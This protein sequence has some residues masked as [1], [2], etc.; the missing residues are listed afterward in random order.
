[1]IKSQRPQSS[2][3]ARRFV[4][5]DFIDASVRKEWTD[6]DIAKYV[7]TY[8]YALLTH[9]VDPD[10]RRYSASGGTTTALLTHSMRSG[11]IDGAVVCRAILIDGKVRAEF[12]IARTPGELAQSQGSKYVE[13]KFLHEVLPL[14]RAYEGRL[15][16]VGLPCDLS[17]LRRWMDK[18]AKIGAKIVYTIGL[19][20]G[21]NS[22]T[23]LIDQVTSSLERKT[24]SQL[25]DYKFRIG[26]W[27]GNI[28]ADFADGQTLTPSTKIF[29]DYQNLFFFCERK[30]LACFDHYAYEA[31]I[32]IG[33]VWLYRLKADPIKRTGVVVRTD[34][35]KA[36]V[37]A[38][39]SAGEINAE[40]LNIRDIMDGQS[41]IG[42]AH[43]NVSARARVAKFFGI[44]LKDPVGQR[45]KWHSYLNAFIT[46]AN[47][48]MSESPLGR[49]IIF[50]TP[51][52][53][54]RAYLVFKK[55]LETL[56]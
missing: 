45:V 43:Y 36:A 25:T 27:R 10:V 26:H 4:F 46:L 8:R 48:R 24:G 38:A 20:C 50:A 39:L 34:A 14:I 51:R 53:V 54:I 37:D 22:R 1:M 18:D 23:G 13:T 28:K 9:S 30:C 21:H 5:G 6:E 32:T 33:D 2:R 55:G 17:A 49:R 7:G 16:V 41:R 44:K 35:G 3:K 40:P 15:A 56:R 12:Y 29:N 31:D 47:L 11:L 52:P 19:V 42:P